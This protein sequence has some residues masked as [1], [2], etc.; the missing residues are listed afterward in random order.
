MGLGRYLV[1]AIALEG[2]SPSDLAK[3]HGISRSWIYELLQRYR[4][5]GYAALEPRSHR[6]RSCPHQVRPNVV[7]AILRL[8]RELLAGG[9]D[10]GAQTIA[11]HL[12]RRLKQVPSTATIWR[13]LRRHGVITPQPHKRPRSSFQRFEAQLP[14]ELWQADATHWQLADG[15]PLE[16]LNLV[17]DHSRLALASVAF[18]TVKAADVVQVFAQA[19]ANHGL[20]AAFLS[21]N[22]AVFSGE[23]RRGTVLLESELA[24][25]GIRAVHARAYHP[26]TC[27]KVERFHQTQKR[28][29]AKQPPATS[30]AH[31]QAQLDHFRSYYNQRRPHRALGQRTPLIAFNARLKARPAPIEAPTQF[32]VRLD[33][34]DGSGRVTV[35]YLSRLRHIYISRKYAGERIRL[36]I[37]GADVRVIRENGQLLGEATLDA[38]RNYQPLRRSAIVHDHLRQVSSIT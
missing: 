7:E 23:Y 5:G 22:A 6:P 2:R 25:L 16:I 37:A 29:L 24:R 26:Q 33:K 12:R 3:R 38:N 31:L 27:G 11:H 36:L 21:D 19:A 1:D 32:R 34:V 18:T 15:S 8:R 10:A 28:F 30:L 20:P 35:R 13:I 9:H 4:D 17:D 14:N